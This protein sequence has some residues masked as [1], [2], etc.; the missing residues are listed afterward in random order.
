MKISTTELNNHK[1]NREEKQPDSRFTCSP[2]SNSGSVVRY[3]C[4]IHPVR[5][6]LG[7]RPRWNTRVFF[8]PMMCCLRLSPLDLMILS[9]PVAFQYPASVALFDLLPL[10]YLRSLGAKKNHSGSSDRISDLSAHTQS[11]R[12]RSGSGNANH[13]SRRSL[14]DTGVN[15]VNRRSGQGFCSAASHQIK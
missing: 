12:Q 11:R 15:K 5:S 4:M 1:L 10:G 9:L 8:M 7:A 14:F 6:P 3:S 2:D 13:L